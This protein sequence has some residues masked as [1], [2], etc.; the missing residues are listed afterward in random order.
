MMLPP[1][2]AMLRN[3][4]ANDGE[5]LAHGWMCRRVTHSCECA[6]IEAPIGACRNGGHCRQSVDID[7]MRRK[8][9]AVFD[10]AQQ[11]SATG[12]E[13]DPGVLTVRG[14][15]STRI[16]RS[17]EQKRVHTYTSFAAARTAATMLG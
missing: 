16:D 10:E 1:S 13:G 3:C 7:Q 9:G 11:I 15:G 2:E 6:D 14:D 12:D 17:R 4:P 5:A 8:G